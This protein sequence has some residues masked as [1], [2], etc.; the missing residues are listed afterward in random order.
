MQRFQYDFIYFT[1][2]GTPED[3]GLIGWHEQSASSEDKS[4]AETCYDM[5]FGNNLIYR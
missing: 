3:R 5:P 4:S 2:K 1:L